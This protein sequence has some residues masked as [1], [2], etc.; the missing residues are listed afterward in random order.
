[1]LK[2]ILLLNVGL[3]LYSSYFM[4]AILTVGQTN[5]QFGVTNKTLKPKNVLLLES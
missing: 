3:L 2:Y 1:M 4:Y 5:L